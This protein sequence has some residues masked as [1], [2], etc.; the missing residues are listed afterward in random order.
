MSKIVV[1]GGDGFIGRHLVRKLA[2]SFDGKIVAFDRFSAYQVS[3]EHPFDEF[4]NVDI[5]PGNFFNRDEVN[6]VL[7]D[8][9]YVFH[10]ISATNPATSNN[11]PFIDIDTNIRSSVELFQLCVE[12]N[13]KKVIFPS[14]GGTVYGDINSDKIDELTVPSPRSPYGIGKLTIEHYLRYFKYTSGLDYIV[15]RIANPFG[16]GQ[17]VH[18]KQGVIPIFMHK[19]VTD[20]TLTIFGDGEM[21]R[22]YIFIDDLIEMILESYRRDNIFNEYNLGCGNGVSINQLVSA[23]ESVTGEV[24]KKEHLET[25]STYAQNSVLNIDRFV[26]EFRILPKTTLQDGIRKTWDYVKEIN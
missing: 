22:D 25:P 13:V 14:S 18:G 20:Q 5:V 15:Y 7:V 24:A 17:N 12:H 2:P 21:V 23:L 19:L 8:A 6:K 4:D 1:F 9:T 11:D 26:S 10:L 3:S 16:P